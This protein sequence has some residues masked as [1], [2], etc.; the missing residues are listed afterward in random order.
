MQ[1]IGVL[2]IHTFADFFLKSVCH[3]CPLLRR[4]FRI[5]VVLC[6]NYRTL[7]RYLLISLFVHNYTMCISVFRGVWHVATRRCQNRCTPGRRHTDDVIV[8]GRSRDRW[9]H[10][11]TSRSASAM[12][13]SVMSPSR[14]MFIVSMPFSSNLSTSRCNWLP[15]LN[16]TRKFAAFI[17]QKSHYCVRHERCKFTQILGF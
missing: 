7:N 8:A 1:H 11:S 3:F 17:S 10:H 2:I 12:S 15:L 16:F 14:T 5:T 13:E 9:R 6:I 4:T